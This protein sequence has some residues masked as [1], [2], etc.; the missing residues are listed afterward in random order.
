MLRDQS[1]EIKFLRKLLSETDTA[2]D[3]GANKG[4]YMYWM[5]QSTGFSGKVYAFEPQQ[6]LANYLSRISTIMGW[7]NIYVSDYAISSKSGTATLNIPGNSVSP[8]ATLE[9][10]QFKNTHQERECRTMMLDQAIPS[11]ER[12]ALLKVDVEGHELDVFR[13]ANRIL[14][15]DRPHILFECETRHLISHSMDDVFVYLKSLGYTGHFFNLNGINPI[16]SF[17]SK[18]HQ[19]SH[20]KSKEYCNNFLFCAEEKTMLGS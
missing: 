13:G 9:P 1:V 18:I 3:I 2:V 4:A 20:P 10:H 11:S 12:V 16:D 15:K 14:N 8:S 7:K 6:E 19:S 5:R 17:K